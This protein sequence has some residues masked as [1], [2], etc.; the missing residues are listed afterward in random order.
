MT[1][2]ELLAEL[3]HLPRDLEVLAF[4]AGCEDYCERELDEL[5]LQGGRV[6]LH[7]GARR[8][9]HHSGSRLRPWPRSTLTWR[10]PCADC[11]PPSASSRSCG[12]STTPTI[13]TRTTTSPPTKSRSHHR[14]TGRVSS[15]A[16]RW[17]GRRPAGAGSDR[18]AAARRWRSS[19]DARPRCAPPSPRGRGT[20][21]RSR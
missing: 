12:S 5:D 11:E 19:R 8:T 2:R 3:Q 21:G 13:T 14:P 7:L 6:Y 15:P 16:A 20:T 17:A 1:V 4:K 10:R 9:S 18:A